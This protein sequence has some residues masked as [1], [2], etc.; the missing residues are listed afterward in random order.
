MWSTIFYS[1][2]RISRSCQ[3]SSALN[4]PIRQIVQTA[5]NII[6][7]ALVV[8]DSGESLCVPESVTLPL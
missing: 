8:L 4:N 5:E 3:T 2:L 7:S 1:A 6:E